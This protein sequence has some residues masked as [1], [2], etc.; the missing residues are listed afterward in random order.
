M[1]LL[2]AVYTWL[3]CR[4]HL[5]VLAAAADPVLAGLVV[6]SGDNKLATLR[7]IHSLRSN[8]S[9]MSNCCRRLATEMNVQG[10]KSSSSMHGFGGGL[11]S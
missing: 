10:L 7:I 8:M 3:Y 4:A 9:S 11:H 1:D 2:M 5:A 6:G